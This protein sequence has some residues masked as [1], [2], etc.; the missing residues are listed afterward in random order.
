MTVTLRSSAAN[1][2]DP[3]KVAAA[4]TSATKSVFMISPCAAKKWIG[5]V[6]TATPM[7]SSFYSEFAA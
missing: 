3:V 5:T 6:T 4:R 2:D 1:D 7:L